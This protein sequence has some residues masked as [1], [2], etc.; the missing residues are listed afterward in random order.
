MYNASDYIR[1]Y[2]SSYLYAIRELREREC[3]AGRDEKARKNMKD[4][5]EQR[6]QENRPSPRSP[7]L[8]SRRMEHLPKLS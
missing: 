2:R 4:L 3:K 8:T 6:H 5:L 7:I 1:D